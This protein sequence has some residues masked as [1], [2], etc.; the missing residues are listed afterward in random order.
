MCKSI[1]TAPVISGEDIKVMGKGKQ[2]PSQVGDVGGQISSRAIHG[3]GHV[4]S[5]AKV[6]DGPASL[7]AMDGGGPDVITTHNN[8]RWTPKHLQTEVLCPLRC[9]PTRACGQD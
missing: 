5:W 2:G 6:W 8:H 7:W 9:A 1:G 4:S 3:D